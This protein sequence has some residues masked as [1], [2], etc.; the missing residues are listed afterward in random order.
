MEKLVEKVFETIKKYKLINDDE[1]VVTG[2]SGGPDS[3]CLLHV[4]KSLAAQL[5][6]RVFAAH[7]N[8]MLRGEE[9]EG[10]ESYVRELC[11]KLGVPLFVS[12]HNV[13]EVSG[14]KGISLEEAGR[15]IRYSE[16]EA[17]SAEIG[18]QKI[19]VAHN[20]NDQAETV[21]LNLLRGAGLDGLKG[22]EYKTGKI[23]RPLLDVPR[24]DIEAYCREYALFPRTDSSNLES[25]YTRN[26]V[27][28]DLIPYIDTLFKKNIV[29]S[30]YRMSSL[31]RDDYHYIEDCIL[32]IYDGFVMKKE[33]KAVWL[34]LE[35]MA[36]AHPAVQK[37]VLRKAIEQ[38][39]GDLKGIESVHLESAVS[40]GTSGKTGSQIHLPLNLRVERSYEALKIFIDDNEKNTCTAFDLPLTIPGTTLIGDIKSSVLAVLKKKPINIEEYGNLGYNSLVQFF[41][42]DRLG[43]GIN[44]RNRRDGDVFKPYRSKGTK[45]LKEYF[46][47]SKIPR[48][49][50]DSIPLIAKGNEVVWVIGYKI[51]DKFKVTE[52]TKSILKLEFKPFGGR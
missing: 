48:H 32:S 14:Q 15:E 6:I 40:L 51:S 16:F 7:V 18:A 9:S 34:S 10:D 45:K 1:G 12:R 11:K 35:K 33:G 2:I 27:R 43:T 5:N 13:G 28:L 49:M 17:L 42:Y 3:V 24:T 29:E 8:H 19:A 39:K 52:N 46:I 50:R 25:D 36:E 22:M 30:L 38:V 4:L 23:I 31:L 20:K 41:D 47:D 44:V 26:K 37:R 21:M